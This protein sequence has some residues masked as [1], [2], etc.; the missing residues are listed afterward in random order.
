M[1]V[2]AVAATCP[3]HRAGPKRGHHRHR[4]GGSSKRVRGQVAAWRLDPGPRPEAVVRLRG[5]V[6]ALASPR[7]RRSGSRCDNPSDPGHRP[8]GR[9]QLVAEVLK[10]QDVKV[11]FFAANEERRATAAWAIL[12]TLVRWRRPKATS[13][14]P[15]LRPRVLARRRGRRPLPRAALGR[16]ARP[17]LRGR[18]RNIARKS[19]VPPGGCGVTGKTAARVPCARRQ[20]VGEAAAAAGLRLPVRPDGR[21]QAF[22]RQFAQRD[23]QQPQ[24]LQKPCATSGRATSFWHIWASGRARTLRRQLTWSR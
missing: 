1:E 4:S 21:R 8:H 22:G 17:G 13:S 23:P 6:A 19:T 11:T 18:L 5:A 20:D 2:M 10:R 3:D 9:G 24:L 12:G 7:R 16:P 15:Y 14:L